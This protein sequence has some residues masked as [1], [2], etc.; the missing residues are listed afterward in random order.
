V[1]AG[2]V[3]G[4]LFGEPY[5]VSAF[6]PA[7]ASLVPPGLGRE[8]DNREGYRQ[9]SFTAEV[10]LAGRAARLAWR[11]WASWTEWRERFEDRS[12]AVQDPTPLDSEPL[13]GGGTL[14]ARATGLRRGDVF[15]SARWTAGAEARLELPA[16]LQASLAAHARE[17]F[18]IPYF[19]VVLVPDPASGAKSVLVAPRLDS[20]RLPALLLLDARIERGFGVGRG[21][22]AL[23][24]EAFNLLNRAT[25]LQVARDVEAPNLGRPREL[26][27]PRVLLLS[28]RWAL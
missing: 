28:L 13:R 2:G 16:G 14:A 4:A 26:L 5:S 11:G 15:L 1:A 17:G 7:D 9:D 24:L 20:H 23:G 8:L 10:E 6:A 18:P 12:R 25:P 19:A 27:R 22:L 3:S 21:R